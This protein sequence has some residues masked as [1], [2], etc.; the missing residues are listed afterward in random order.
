M[1]LEE[2]SPELRALGERL[3]A[4]VEELSGSRLAPSGDWYRTEVAGSP[5]LWFRFVG[6]RARKYPKNS[7][8][9]ATEWSDALAS[10]NGV[11]AGNNWYGQK[12]SADL[13]VRP[14]HPHEIEKAEE[15]IRRTF[16]SRGAS[17]PARHEAQHDR[18]SRQSPLGPLPDSSSAPFPF[19]DRKAILRL[20]DL[21]WNEI[22]ATEAAEERRFEQDFA[23]ARSSGYLSKGLFLRVA[24]WKSPR[25]TPNH[26]RNSDA[27]IRGATSEALKAIDDSAA[28][29]ALMRLSGVALRTASAILHW[30]RP[31]RF[32][33]LDFRVV[34]ALGEPEP[35]SFESFEL[36]GRIAER[37]HALARQHQLD[38]RTIDRALWT[39][40]RLCRRGRA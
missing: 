16:G 22:S 1:L 28:L 2:T 3:F 18:E 29:S 21:Y 11:T 35:K 10:I 26:E 39:W 25:Q 7:V 6:R 24:R 12:R 5:A 20:A 17:I 30:L 38:L 32:P 4:L 23:E 33:I 37:V 13:S 8:H 27:S 15:F 19:K 36:Y 9:L 40:D 14:G 31:D 34:A